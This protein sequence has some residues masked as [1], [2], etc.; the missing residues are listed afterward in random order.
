M[1]LLPKN[2]FVGRSRL[3]ASIARGVASFNARASQTS[4]V[5]NR[6]TIEV[7]TVTT[8]YLEAKDRICKSQ[9]SEEHVQKQIRNLTKLKQARQIMSEESIYEAGG[10]CILKALINI[11][12]M[13]QLL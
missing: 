8:V 13:F 3:K 4:D 1:V 9:K 6:L 2:V 5:M 7:D 11:V 12:Y 10:Y